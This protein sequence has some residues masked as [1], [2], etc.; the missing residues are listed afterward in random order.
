MI[1]FHW[2][3]GLWFFETIVMGFALSCALTAK[4]STWHAGQSS[5]R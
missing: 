1:V 4:D 3:L 2:L 5:R